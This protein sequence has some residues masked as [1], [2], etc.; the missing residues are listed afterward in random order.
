MQ[1][2][3][4]ER[5]RLSVLALTLILTLIPLARV[6]AQT[7]VFINEIHYDN[8]GIDVG[9]AVEIAGPGGTDLTGWSI[10]LYNG[11]VGTVYRTTSLS[12]IIPDQQNG[13]GTVLISYATNRLQNGSPDGIALVD[14]TGTVVQFISYEGTF[15]AV[16]GP[17]DGMLS[18]DIGVQEGSSTPIGHSLQLVGTGS[19]DDDFT[20]APAAANTYGA[21]NAGQTFVD[22]SDPDYTPIY[23][24]QYTADPSGDSP[25]AG[26]VDITTEGIVTARFQYG[27]FIEDPAGGAW[28][29]LWIHDTDNF[30]ALGDR[31]RLTGTVREYYG[32]TELDYLTD[33]QVESSGNPLP[34]AVVLATGDAS[35]EQW[36]GV[37]VRVENVTVSNED[38]GYGEWSVTDGSGDVVIDDKGSYA[39]T[40]SSGDALDAIMGP[41][42]F[43]YGAF[44]I[45]PRDDS[46]IIVP[47]PPSALV[48]NEILA[49]PAGDL[50]GDANG[51]GVRSSHEDEFVEIVNNSDDAIDIS[52]WTL[53]DGYD[54]RHTFPAGTIVSARCGIVVFGGGAPSGPFGGML[55]QTASSGALGLNNT[56]DTITL[57]DGATEE[58][59]VAYG[60]EGSRDQ[61]LTR[62]PDLTGSFVLHTTATG[63]DRALFSPGTLIDG[64]SFP[65]CDMCGRPATFIHEVQGSGLESPLSGT[66]GVVIEGVVVGDF[67]DT[68][69]QLRGFFIQEEDS[70]AD[71]N[72]ATSEGLFVYDSGFGVDVVPGD[73]VRV[74]G[75]VTEYYGLTQM[76]SVSDLVV[77]GTGATATAAVVNLPIPDLAQWEAYEGMLITIPQTLY[78]SDSYN[79]GKYGELRLSVGGRL[80]APTNIV[81]PG[82]EALALQDLNDRSRILLDDG[83]NLQYPL[84]MPPYI[85]DDDTLRAG[86][87][88][89]GLTGVV[90][91]GYSTYR[92]HPT[93]PV[94]FTRVNERTTAPQPVGGRLKVA[95][96]NVLNYFNGDGLGG[97]FPTA[98]GA[99]TPE[100]FVRQRTKII[101]AILTL[102]ADVIGLMEIEN[103]GHAATSAI[104]DL[105]NGLND[106]TGPGTY[107]F[108]DA[109]GPIGTDE[110]TVGFI[111]KPATVTPV[112]AAA[113]LDSS[114]DPTFN[115]DK[116]RPALAQ[117]F[118][119][120]GT[121]ERFTAVVNHLKSKG[122]DCDDIGDPN[123]DD[124]QGNCPATRLNAAIALTN[125]LAG[126]PTVSG[127]PD[128]LIIGDLNAYAME[129]PITAIEGA[130]YTDLLE[131]YA[132]ASAYS[133]VY[134]G[135]AGYLDHALANGDLNPQ[136]TGATVWHIN[137]DEPNGLNYYDD[138]QPGLY[139]PGPYRSSDHDPV[140]IG[141]DLY[142]DKP[143][144]DFELQLAKI[145]WY[146]PNDSRRPRFYLRGEFDLPEGF[147]PDDLSRDLEVCV[148]VADETGCDTI[149]LTEDKRAWLCRGA[150]GQGEGLDLNHVRIVW[151]SQG[152]RLKLMGELNLPGIDRDTRPAEA[153]IEIGFP[154]EAPGTTPK[155]VAELFVPFEVRQWFW[156]YLGQ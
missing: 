86:D 66:S 99:E 146:H 6:S 7:N 58:V 112:G 127:D 123:M 77:C 102:D 55:V 78:A 60:S 140:L 129:D 121:G 106:A 61:S 19:T 148:T 26:Q 57:S 31:V 114:V 53:A 81:S 10:V 103:D 44:K 51:D 36:E 142:S 29:G 16:G 80:A 109:G 17:A 8:N 96:Y 21:P 101:N 125:W 15:T 83:S 72:S 46:D 105:V 4:R 20:W 2:A 138:N 92:V 117:T 144:E 50:T 107:A 94:V 22:D 153:V 139:D 156:F 84:P 118:E 122:S 42:D 24:I 89:P 54:V 38:L 68:T 150:D 147:T 120:N 62:D 119:E 124:G 63:S 95:S 104:A 34:A 74:E 100:E 130:G 151:T 137:A 145:R 75:S 111:Y 136:V 79:L 73:V 45:Q 23:D 128:F 97:G 67:Q 76:N 3:K 56:G 93:Q 65:G 116:N 135:Q 47:I 64:A 113:I 71:A 110:I 25:L 59:A 131:A 41:V 18:T 28:N 91:Y 48:I 132:G 14:S 143:L 13:Y 35:Q 43:G 126:D 70:D 49:D 90:S 152:T 134:Y 9:E 1:H 5:I 154:V 39:Y 87:T 69:T 141:L 30:P 33:Y 85:G 108:V 82:A 133:Y 37:L 40:P 115:D 155:L 11:S 12:D 27:Y 32:L 98:R 149:A 88:T 52:G